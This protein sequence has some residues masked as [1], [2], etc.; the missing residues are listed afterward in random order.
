MAWQRFYFS[1]AVPFLSMLLGV[2]AQDICITHCLH[3]QVCWWKYHGNNYICTKVNLQCILLNVGL[4]H[5]GHVPWRH[6]WWC[7]PN[8]LDSQLNWFLA[9]SIRIHSFIHEFPKK[10]NGI[11]KALLNCIFCNLFSVRWWGI[12]LHTG[13]KHYQWVYSLYPVLHILFI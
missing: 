6:I 13:I 3:F 5:Y 10:L 2:V 4:P 12:P 11:V 9:A 1:W 8:S 7:L